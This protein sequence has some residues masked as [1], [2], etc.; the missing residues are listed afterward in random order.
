MTDYMLE[1]LTDP[2][3][4]K[5]MG[6]S[7]E[8]TRLRWKAFE[9]KNGEPFIEWV[10]PTQLLVLAIYDLIDELRKHK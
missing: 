9:P 10:A 4:R 1:K 2:D 6:E 5:L 7:L 8:A 3:G